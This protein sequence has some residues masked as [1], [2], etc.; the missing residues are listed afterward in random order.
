M[1]SRDA[2]VFVYAFEKRRRAYALRLRR[3]TTDDEVAVEPAIFELD[4]S[5]SGLK[6]ALATY[7]TDSTLALTF[8]G[9]DFFVETLTY[10]QRQDS[11]SFQLLHRTNLYPDCDFCRLREEPCE[12]PR[13]LWQRRMEA[14]YESLPGTAN[15]WSAMKFRVRSITGKAMMFNMCSKR[16]V[17]STIIMSDRRID[18]D[19]INATAN[20]T[21][22]SVD[23]RLLVAP[24]IRAEGTLSQTRQRSDTND[25]NSADP[26]GRTSSARIAQRSFAARTRYDDTSMASISASAAGS[27]NTAMR[28]SLKDRTSLSTRRACTS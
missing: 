10:E 13:P 7:R 22:S 28:A 20:L 14:V 8:F 5:T 25:N 12:C 17:R 19:L 6:G 21:L 2:S 16:E 23:K 4:E 18:Q 1:N 26:E 27:A 11:K 9:I 3:K 24:G 15:V